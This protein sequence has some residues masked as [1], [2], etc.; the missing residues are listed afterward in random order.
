MSQ[1]LKDFWDTHLAFGGPRAKFTADDVRAV[2]EHVDGLEDRNLARATVAKFNSR[3][4]NLRPIPACKRRL[5]AE[6]MPRSV[7]AWDTGDDWNGWAMPRVDAAALQ[8]LISMHEEI[9]LD[10]DWSMDGS[11]LVVQHGDDPKGAPSRIEPEDTPDMGRVWNVSLGYT[12]EW[13]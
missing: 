4:M 6:W 10:D 13:E 3:G 1:W 11:T 5:R 7:W 8:S 12:W 9:G 2:Q